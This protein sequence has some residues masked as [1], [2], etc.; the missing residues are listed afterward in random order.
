MMFLI[1]GTI[2]TNCGQWCSF[3]GPPCS[4]CFDVVSVV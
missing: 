1:Y 4:H 3:F 2:L